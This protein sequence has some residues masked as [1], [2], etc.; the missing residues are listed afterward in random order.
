MCFNYEKMIQMSST[1]KEKMYRLIYINKINI[2]KNINNEITQL[3]DILILFMEEDNE[4][5]WGSV[6]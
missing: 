5:T 4:Y 6:A 3:I 2:N 1:F